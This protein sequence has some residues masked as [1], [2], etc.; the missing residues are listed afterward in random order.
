MNTPRVGIGRLG[1]PVILLDDG[2]RTFHGLPVTTATAFFTAFGPGQQ[3]AEP[4]PKLRVSGVGC[5][6][7]V[8]VVDGFLPLLPA[9]A[10]QRFLVILFRLGVSKN[11]GH[12]GSLGEAQN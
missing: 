4:V 1:P 11:Q 9:F 12:S 5:G 10:G 7:Q 3:L 2:R 8:I 6:S